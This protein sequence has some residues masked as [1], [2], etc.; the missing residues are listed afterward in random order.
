MTP[1]IFLDVDGVLN[2]VRFLSDVGRR[3]GSRVIEALRAD[4]MNLEK[5]LRAARKDRDTWGPNAKLCAYCGKT[6]EGK[7]I[8]GPAHRVCL[9]CAQTVGELAETMR[10]EALSA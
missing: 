2:C 9:S 8:N 6:P 1:I 5:R 3:A 7:A 10:Q 4:K